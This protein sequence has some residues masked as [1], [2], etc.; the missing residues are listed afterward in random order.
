MSKIKFT[1][2]KIKSLKP[3]K[4][5][6]EYFQEGRTPGTGAF[7]FRI[8]PNGNR[9]WYLYYRNDSGKLRRHRLGS[10][11]EVS[12]AEAEKRLT[13]ELNKVNRGRDP[14]QEVK[15]HKSAPTMTD[16][17]ELFV[18]QRGN[19]KRQKAVATISEENRRWEKVIKPAMGD[20]RVE[21]VRP[22][23]LAELLDKVA[24][25]A[26]VSANRL[27]SLLQILFKPAL[28]RGWIEIH[29][30]HWID[31]PGGQEDSRKRFLSEAE[32]KA[33]WPC[34]D[35][36]RANPRD[37]LKLGLYTAQRPGEIQAMKWADVD[38]DEAIWRQPTNKTDTYHLVPLSKQV[39]KILEDRK[40]YQAD[41]IERRAKRYKIKAA[42]CEYVFQT[43]HNQNRSG[44]VSPHTTSLKEARKKVAKESG[45]TGW[46]SHDLRRTARTL[47]SAIKVEREIRGRLLNHAVGGVEGVYDMHDFLTEK[48]Q[49]LQRLANKI[50]QIVDGK[51]KKFEKVVK[52]RAN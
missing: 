45:V 15:D 32:I 8:T 30:L 40:V 35:R 51:E 22:V 1:A 12:L 2:V 41:E 26:P 3:S 20:L 25:T 44:K 5:A 14:L 38:L 16:L 7:C 29:P 17:W 27:H 48:R 19:A 39:A 23:D 43:F 24:A 37:I 18:Q 21:A 10:Y 47:L 4:K 33:V 42:P 13:K 31:K 52:L 9:S 34:F 6:V 36:L 49:A 50:D 11:P 46:T 28:A